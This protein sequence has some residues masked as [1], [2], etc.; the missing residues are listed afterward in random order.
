MQAT[1]ED[2]RVGYESLG[3]GTA[4]VLMHAFP[5]N[6][7][8]YEAQAAALSGKARVITF[9]FPGVGRSEGA[10]LTM[11]GMA[12]LTA[13][14]LDAL[15]ISKAV[16]G[17]VSMG[18]YAA[19]AFAR[20]H[21]DRL[22]GLLLANTRAASDTDEA[23]KGRS[24]MADVA[25]REGAAAIA[26][27]MIPKL[28]S[29]AARKKQRKV[30]ERTR[31][32]IEATPPEVIADLLKALAG[33]EDSTPFLGEIGVPTMV[34]AGEA[35]VITPAEESRSWAS[36]IPGAEYVEIEKAGHLANLEAPDAFN[37]AVA[38]LLERVNGSG[39]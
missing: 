4:L 1:I 36:E 13:K 26:D 9:D 11:D 5:L 38:R 29:E 19:L 10:P 16:V 24:E 23:K 37:Q 22:A 3:S 31:E 30:V 6:R 39:G 8:M 12:D 20:R 17:G 15:Q 18:G 7:T 2:R 14:L 35:D 27:R 34:I 33:R 32:M 25:L 21:P 28:F